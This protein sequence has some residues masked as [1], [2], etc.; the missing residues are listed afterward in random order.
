MRNLKQHLNKHPETV[1]D[2]HAKPE[3][4]R[5][6]LQVVYT[7]E[8]QFSLSFELELEAIDICIIRLILYWTDEEF[9]KYPKRVIF[10]VFDSS[11]SDTLQSP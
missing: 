6:L 7:L 5:S 1:T 9:V 11:P 8:I 4:R 2:P 3:E 10:E